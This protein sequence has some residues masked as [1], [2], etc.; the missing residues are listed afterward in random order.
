MRL[1]PTHTS[2]AFTL[3]EVLI[4]TSLFAVFV[5]SISLIK[6]RALDASVLSEETNIAVMLAE[7]KM[8]ELESRLLGENFNLISETDE[9]KWDAPYEAYSWKREL[10]EVEIPRYLLATGG[11]GYDPN[12]PES[13]MFKILSDHINKTVREL[14]L[15]VEWESYVGQEQIKVSTFLVKQDEDLSLPF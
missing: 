2:K 9:G 10:R 1:K 5:G 11:E 7:N 14:T 8:A 15:T 4:A 3:I 6:S 13:T 12:S